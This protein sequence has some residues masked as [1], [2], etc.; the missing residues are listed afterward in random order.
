MNTDKLERKMYTIYILYSSTSGK[1]YVGL[2]T[3]LDRRILEHNTSEN[4]SFTKS[5]RPWELVYTEQYGTKLE[6]VRR[7][8]F[9]KSGVGRKLKQ[10]II[11][12][13][14]RAKE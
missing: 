4:A 10:E 12:E 3:D 14:L 11:E 6:A 13:Y 5:Y 1:T 7:E 9:Y 8:K 2:T